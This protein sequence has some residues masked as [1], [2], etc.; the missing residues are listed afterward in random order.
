MATPAIKIAPAIARPAII[1]AVIS[2]NAA[3]NNIALASVVGVVARGDD[4]AG[5][6]GQVAMQN[7]QMTNDSIYDSHVSLLNGD[8][9]PS[10]TP[11]S[12]FTAK[13]KRSALKGMV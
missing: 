2:T 1:A 11:R 5:L 8:L 4:T 3:L 7:R 6:H 12:P 13:C 9:C 10:L